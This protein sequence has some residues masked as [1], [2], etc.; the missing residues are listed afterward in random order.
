MDET[1]LEEKARS[2]TVLERCQLLFLPTL[3]LSNGYMLDGLREEEWIRWSQRCLFL[4]QTGT[5]EG[6]SEP[7]F[8]VPWTPAPLPKVAYRS[9]YFGQH[10]GL[11]LCGTPVA[12]PY[13]SIIETAQ[14]THR[15]KDLGSLACISP[16][17]LE[18]RPIFFK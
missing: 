13:I 5:G 2:P 8:Q 1:C 9:K 4:S 3:P 15:I 18:A 7:G 6:S 16:K 12:L 17:P 10:R 11:T 14:D